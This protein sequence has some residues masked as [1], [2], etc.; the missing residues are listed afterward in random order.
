MSD[1][2]QIIIAILFW[3]QVSPIHP[4]PRKSSK[5]AAKKAWLKLRHL[6]RSLWT[7]IRIPNG[8]AKTIAKSAAAEYPGEKTWEKWEKFIKIVLSF[9]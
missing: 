1:Y 2:W 3:S 8:M 4:F 5:C 7:S 6:P 9:S